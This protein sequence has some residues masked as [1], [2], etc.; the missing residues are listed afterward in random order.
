[1]HRICKGDYPLNLPDEQR[2]AFEKWFKDQTQKRE[3]GT[4]RGTTKDARYDPSNGQVTG[5]Y[6]TIRNE[7]TMSMNSLGAGGFL[8]KTRIRTS[9]DPEHEIPRLHRWFQQNQHPSREQMVVYLNELNSL[10]SRRGRKPLDLTN[11]IYWF[12]NARAAQRRANRSGDMLGDDPSM[13]VEDSNDDHEGEPEQ[14]GDRLSPVSADSVPILPNKNAV[15]VV[16]SPLHHPPQSSHASSRSNSPVIHIIPQ[17]PSDLSE[18][19]AEHTGAHG[20]N[21]NIKEDIVENGHDHHQHHRPN[22]SEADMETMDEGRENGRDYSRQRSESMDSRGSPTAGSDRD[23]LDSSGS[24]Q[25]S[26]EESHK[27]SHPKMEIK[28]EIDHPREIDYP[29]PPATSTP[30]PQQ[31]MMALTSP[32]PPPAH[33]S[34]PMAMTAIPHPMN[35]HYM[36]PAAA[37]ALYAGLDSS[38]LLNSHSHYKD[39][40]PLSAEERKKRSRV[41]IDPLTEIPKLEKWF[42]EDTHPS[43]YMIEKYTEELNRSEYRQ[44]FPKLE[45]KNVQLWFKNHRAKVKR[46]RLEQSPSISMAS[47]WLIY[48]FVVVR[49][50]FFIYFLL[51]GPECSVRL[52]LS[53]LLIGCDDDDDYEPFTCRDTNKKRVLALET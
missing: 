25:S 10:E 16:S 1:M 36:H 12:K 14:E 38:S 34:H 9:F 6:P 28:Q 23:R 31:H 30:S 27:S 35:L 8:P 39:S 53:G 40:S 47:V 37:H 13:D 7:L 21:N 43:S 41:F 18:H 2:Q 4:E 26:T 24:G 46:G 17:D 49:V 11:I 51:F 5:S 44:R 33:Q 32:Q 42:A 50:G 48:Y 29:S 22:H 45:P 19:T 15:Y 20:L 3:P 52:V